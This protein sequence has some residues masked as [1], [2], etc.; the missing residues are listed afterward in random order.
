ML[1]VVRMVEEQFH[2]DDEDRPLREGRTPAEHLRP[3]DIEYK[4][5]RA[6]STHCR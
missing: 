4:P 2:R 6:A 1:L 5:A 3:G